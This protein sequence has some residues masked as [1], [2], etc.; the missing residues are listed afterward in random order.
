MIE[1]KNADATANIQLRLLR[2]QEE[3]A[4]RQHDRSIALIGRQDESVRLRAREMQSVAEAQRRIQ[5]SS[6]LRL[7]NGS[8]WGSVD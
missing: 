6:Q 8:D 1:Q 2:S 3:I 5:S 4:S 7:E